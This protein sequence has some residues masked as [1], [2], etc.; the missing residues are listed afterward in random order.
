MTMKFSGNTCRRLQNR[1]K[2]EQLLRK[3]VRRVYLGY[4]TDSGAD[5]KQ[6]AAHRF[7]NCNAKSL[8]ERTIEKNMSSDQYISHVS[9][10]YGTEKLNALQKKLKMLNEVEDHPKQIERVHREVDI[11]LASPRSA[12][13]LVHRRR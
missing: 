6:A 9:V 12:T 8:S 13:S 5:A 11:F 1:F 7:Q 2:N 3:E 10:L 4:A